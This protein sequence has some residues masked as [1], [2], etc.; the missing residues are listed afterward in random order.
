MIKTKRAISL[1]VS[2]LIIIN[3]SVGI[4]FSAYATIYT[5]NYP[6]DNATYSIDSETGVMIVSGEG[7][8][9]NYASGT[10]PI[11]REL[12]YLVKTVRITPTITGIG[13]YIFSNGYYERSYNGS[14]YYETV[15]GCFKN[16]ESV[17]FS[18]AI[19]HIDDH[20]FFGCKS[21]KNVS[22]P[23]S[24]KYIKSNAFENCTALENVVIN[25][26]IE[27]L[28]D[29]AFKGNANMCTPNF[30]SSLKTI[31]SYCFYGCSSMTGDVVLK[32]NVNSV[33]TNAF[34]G[35]DIDS[36]T[37]YNYSCE[38]PTS[39]GVVPLTTTIIGHIG[40]TAQQYAEKFGYTFEPISGE[41]T[42][43]VA[44]TCIER[45]Y[46]IHRCNDCGAEFID[47]YTDS[48]GH[49]E[50]P[51][52]ALLP[53]CT[54]AGHTNGYKCSVCGAIINGIDRIPAYGHTEKIT[55]EGKV[56]TCT[57][58]GLTEEVKCEV[59][60]AVLQ[61]QTVIP[62]NGHNYI[63]IS[64]TAPECTKTGEKKY[65]CT[66]CEDIKIEVVPATGHSYAKTVVP[67]T[68]LTQ[69]FTYNECTDCGDNFKSDY[70]AV[71]ETHSYESKITTAPT[72][73]T[74]GVRTYT[75]SICGDAYTKV[76]EKTAHTPET[77]A[78]VSPTCTKTGLT[79]G[80]HCSV[81]SYVIT[82][83]Q[84]VNAN[85]H[86]YVPVVT[87]PTCKEQG[88]TTY[89]C[90]VCGDSYKAN[91]TEVTTNH[92]YKATVTKPATCNEDGVKT[93]TCSVCGDKYT[94]KIDKTGNH[95]YT[96][97]VTT[98]AT[99]T[100]K[101]VKT[102]T[103]SVCGNKYTEDIDML[104]HTAVTDS[105]VAPTCTK[106]GLTAGSHCSLCGYVIT[107][108]QVINAK[109]HTPVSSNNAIEPTCTEAGKESDTKC[110]ECGVRLTIGE[111][112][113]ANGHTYV[114]AVTAPTCKEQG[115][116][117]YTCSICG[118][119]YKAD[120]TE[121]TTNH[122]YKVTVT[123]PA[124]C[125]EDGVKTFTCSVC[126]EKYTEKIDKTGNHNYTSAVTTPATCT[127][128]GRYRYA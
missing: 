32:S 70:I 18:Q 23:S 27:L 53:S 72:C 9:N 30:P 128:N 114:P 121:V 124:T 63:L 108:Q 45:G 22:I 13:S 100:T 54:E 28:S 39:T 62:A 8:I 97:A 82:A 109:G 5:G 35:T 98:P 68:C 81:C 101:G 36:I 21:L 115:Y 61:E 113:S 3:I 99:C 90:S 116:T 107:A 91:Y 60:S 57:E 86:T 65:K 42:E 6:K 123:K 119:S 58:T 15:A 117:T 33:G 50:V 43:I 94:E 71:A 4:E 126:G 66:V 67:P 104:E 69:G 37:I 52:A 59:C 20:A 79:S 127:S 11:K 64:E 92:D 110:S 95:N 56:S 12:A 34:A 111:T 51:V 120:Y 26:S 29:S 7:N 75:C 47:T 103:C 41:T 38:L 44:P 83:Q 1:F 40:S 55:K 125:N 106:S 49:T 19:T 80:S 73:T 93:F 118:D 74:T 105:A 112:I 10:L 31:E 84:V 48:L 88:Y 14:I 102:F 46:T 78:A 122:D 87:A 2:L 16:L 89:T 76:I 25:N 85:V 96:F 17:E 24:C 77:D